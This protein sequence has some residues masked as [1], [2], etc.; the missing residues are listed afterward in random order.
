[1][2]TLEEVIP[3]WF[4]VEHQI[5]RDYRVGLGVSGYFQVSQS[6]VENP[7]SEPLSVQKVGERL[8]SFI[9]KDNFQLFTFFMSFW[10][11][12]LKK[13]EEGIIWPLVNSS[14]W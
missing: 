5:M 9:F 4:L 8:H 13:V 11:G 6:M 1:M 7:N 12:F 14:K 2:F 10:K 3:L